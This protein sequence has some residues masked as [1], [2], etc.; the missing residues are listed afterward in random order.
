MI[1]LYTMMQHK[2][3]YLNKSIRRTSQYITRPYGRA[4]HKFTI[5]K[6]VTT[7]LAQLSSVNTWLRTN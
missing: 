3:Q 1:V 7:G 2:S 5:Y 6:R 4:Y